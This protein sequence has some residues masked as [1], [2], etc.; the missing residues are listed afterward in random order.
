MSYLPYASQGV[1]SWMAASGSSIVAHVLVAFAIVGGTQQLL[2]LAATP[3]VERP[4]F[5][6]TLDR[7]D[8]DT[9]AMPLDNPE[10]EAVAPETEE[11]E[12]VAALAPDLLQG[13]TPEAAEP[14]VV[15]PEEVEAEEETPAETPEDLT[16]E[17]PEGLEAE[18]VEAATPDEALGAVDGT[19]AL[20]PTAETLVAE[21]VTPTAEAITALDP[22]VLDSGPI[23]PETVTGVAPSGPGT[24]APLAPLAA[25]T[26]T[27]IAPVGNAPTVAVVP[28]APQA[29][30]IASVASPAPQTTPARPAPE[31]RPPSEQD[32]ALADL[33][34]RIRTTPAD[35]CLVALPRRDGP[36]GVGV[37]IIAASDSAMT[38]FSDRF[39]TPED[40][41][42]R[43]TRTL[44]DDR[45]CPA[46]AYMRENDDYPATRLG[47][48]LDSATVASSANLTGILRGIGGRYL[49]LMLVDN[50]GVAQDLQRFL[51]FSGDFARLDVPVTRA[52]PLRDTNQMLLAIATDRPAPQL[53]ARAG[54]LA[55]DVFNGLD[56]QA[57]GAAALA[58]VTFEVR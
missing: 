22:V 44:I 28:V 27:P 52:G 20:A 14:E 9:I 48:A 26:I 46:L 25:D 21:P 30:T 11:P 47:V 19:D 51:S 4:D 2:E 6:V 24:V 31:T 41:G 50:N 10:L 13:E 8:T 23:I 1:G 39:F 33:I 55:Q 53:K 43:Q 36:E 42:V 7:L 49:T 57:G 17:V 29:E 16:P 15:K 56:G 18:T 34:R 5:V 3:A 35:A 58:L 12:E 54:Q 38:E 40:A 45:Q 32:L 37:E